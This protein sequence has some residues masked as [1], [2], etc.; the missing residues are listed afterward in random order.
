[1]AET[2]ARNR[3]AMPARTSIVMAFVISK[4]ESVGGLSIYF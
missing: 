4:F 3:F 1:M 2:S